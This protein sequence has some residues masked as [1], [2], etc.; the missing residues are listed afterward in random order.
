MDRAE[1]DLY[2][3]HVLGIELKIGTY[4]G[5]EIPVVSKTHVMKF[6]GCRCED[7]RG[8]DKCCYNRP[9]G[10]LGTAASDLVSGGTG[11]ATNDESESTFTGNADFAIMGAERHVTSLYQGVNKLSKARGSYP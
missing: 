3:E 6:S 2:W 9:E 10:E 4:V 1:E 5:R 7:I 11:S 8:Y